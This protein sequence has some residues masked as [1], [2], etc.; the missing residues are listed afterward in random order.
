MVKSYNLWEP[1]AHRKVINRDVVFDEEYMLKVNR[2]VG[3]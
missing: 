2:D 1:V 3:N